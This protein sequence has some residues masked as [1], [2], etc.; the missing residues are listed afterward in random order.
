MPYA[1]PVV[2]LIEELKRLP[3]I[4]PRTAQRLALYLLSAPREQAERLAAAIKEARE[5]VVYC[6]VCGDFTDTDPCNICADPARDHSVICVVE[7]PRDVAAIERSGSFRGVYHVLG[8]ALSPLDGIG[9]ER[10]RIKELL[11]RLEK[12]GVAEVVLATSPD[13]EGEATALYLQRLLEPLGMKLSRLA[14][15]LP[16]GAEI[17]FADAQTIT[18]AFEGRREIK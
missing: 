1:R 15:G 14:Y 12:G 17:E 2:R 10:L 13:T 9:P 7:E 16:V 4:G 11:A 5:K 18:R 6:S 3:G 8:G